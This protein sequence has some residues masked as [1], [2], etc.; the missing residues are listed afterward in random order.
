MKRN[1]TMAEGEAR[2]P[3]VQSLQQKTKHKLPENSVSGLEFDP[4]SYKNSA[5]RD[6][7]KDKISLINNGQLQLRSSSREAIYEWCRGHLIEQ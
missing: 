2:Q 7:N 1:A 6:C 3:H 4:N 5:V